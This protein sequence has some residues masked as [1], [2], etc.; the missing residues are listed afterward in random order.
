LPPSKQ[1]FSGALSLSGGI[2]E[3]QAGKGFDAVKKRFV[4]RNLLSAGKYMQ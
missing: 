1:K 2:P 3:K 4:K